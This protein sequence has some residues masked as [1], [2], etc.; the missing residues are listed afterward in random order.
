MKRLQHMGVTQ[1]KDEN[2]EHNFEVSE[3]PPWSQIVQNWNSKATQNNNNG[4][5]TSGPM[6]DEPVIV[7]LDKYCTQFRAQHHHQ[8]RQIRIGPTGLFSTGTNLI[9][10]LLRNNC[11]GPTDNT[12]AKFAIIQVPVRNQVLGFSFGFYYYFGSVRFGSS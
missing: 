12:R 7:G 4:K 6:D 11:H 10:A 5:P 3:L 2:N 9:A 1:Q 8:Q